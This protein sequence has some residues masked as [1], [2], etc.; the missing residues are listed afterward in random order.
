[1]DASTISYII[2]GLARQLSRIHRAR[3]PPGLRERLLAKSV[4][5]WLVSERVNVRREQNAR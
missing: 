1:M 5:G 3:P 2:G 4:C